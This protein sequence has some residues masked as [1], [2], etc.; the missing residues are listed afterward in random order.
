MNLEY[1]KWL[2]QPYEKENNLSVIC[3]SYHS[4][5]L[6]IKLLESLKRNILNMPKISVEVLIYEDH[7]VNDLL[8]KYVSSID[9]KNW[10]YFA[11]PEDLSTND[12]MYGRRKGIEIASSDYITF[13]DGDDLLT[14]DAWKA[15]TKSI[16]LLENNKKL[17]IARFNE[18][19]ILEENRNNFDYDRNQI[20]SKIQENLNKLS[21]NYTLSLPDYLSL[22]R[23][24]NF[25]PYYMWDKVYRA[26]F[27]KN[28]YLYI[29]ERG[30]DVQIWLE[31]ANTGVVNITGYVHFYGSDNHLQRIIQESRKLKN[32]RF[33]RDQI[34]RK[35]FV[36]AYEHKVTSHRSNT[37]K[38]VFEKVKSLIR[39]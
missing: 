10:H 4:V 22:S 35:A 19:L 11:V 17:L 25:F 31:N 27:L 21:K 3:T 26:S 23:K 29:E 24:V 15:Y 18:V 33:E 20:E 37:L 38:K 13:L 9:L 2:E 14:D 1:L 36:E 8:E 5:E 12:S 34:L 28:T 6:T 7:R 39:S 16:E 30:L 32:D